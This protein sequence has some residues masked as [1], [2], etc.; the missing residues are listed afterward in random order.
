MLFGPGFFRNGLFLIFQTIKDII[1]WHFCLKSANIEKSAL[2]KCIVM[3]VT[4]MVEEN[5]LIW[6]LCYLRRFVF[7]PV[8]PF[9]GQP[10][11][12][13]KEPIGPRPITKAKA[14]VAWFYAV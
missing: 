2:T 11:L 5:P 4:L 9:S 14:K 6:V 7:A 8:W 12:R 3:R 13:S 1:Y 10:I